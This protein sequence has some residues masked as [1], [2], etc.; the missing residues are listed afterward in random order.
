MRLTELV[1]DPFEGLVDD[2]PVSEAEAEARRAVIEVVVEL[3]E[4]DEDDAG[5]EQAQIE[6]D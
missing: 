2:E 1:Q 5:S 3:H 6:D 4:G